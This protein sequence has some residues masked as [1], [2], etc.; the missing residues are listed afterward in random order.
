MSRA[1][2]LLSPILLALSVVPAFAADTPFT[3][4]EARALVDRHN[5]WRAR[6]KVGP[7]AWDAKLASYAQEWAS[8]L[9]ATNGFDHR[10]D[11]PYGENLW[12]GTTGGFTLDAVIDMW[13]GEDRDYDVRSNTCRDGR[14]CGHFTQLVWRSSLRVGCGRALNRDR[15]DV[16]V[17]NYDPP[18]NWDG[19]NPFGR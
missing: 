7:L 6:Y 3:P 8:R 18:G 17:C 9:A 11:N 4:T 13:G 14:V 19:Q 10:P 16:I 1:S 2:N 15:D 5:Q 12:S